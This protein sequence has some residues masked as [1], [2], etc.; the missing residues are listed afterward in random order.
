MGDI[1]A[2]FNLAVCYDNGDGVSQDKEKAIELYQRASDMG[3]TYAMAQPNK[4]E[5]ETTI[6][7]LT[8]DELKTLIQLAESGDMEAALLLSSLLY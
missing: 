4:H 6:H 7:D 2:M 1:N 5:K 8:E 3:N